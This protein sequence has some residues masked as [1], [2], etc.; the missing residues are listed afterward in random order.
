MKQIKQGT[1]N[2]IFFIIAIGLI[3]L[4]IFHGYWKIMVMQ[5]FTIFTTE[6]EIES[7]VPLPETLDY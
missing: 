2:E 1:A 3:A 4:S 7:Y 6:E 5:D